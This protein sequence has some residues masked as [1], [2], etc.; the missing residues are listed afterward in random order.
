L[1]DSPDTVIFGELSLAGEIRLVSKSKQRIKA[2]KQAGF[3][4]VLSPEDDNSSL[5]VSTIK[6]L[7]KKA[8]NN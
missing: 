5:M 4:K 2:A 3:S 7:I 6:E 8:F 1:P